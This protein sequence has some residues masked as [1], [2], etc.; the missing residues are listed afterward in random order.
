MHVIMGLSGFEV[1]NYQEHYGLTREKDKDGFYEAVG[2]QHSW[3]NAGS[4]FTFRLERHAAH[5]VHKFTPMQCCLSLERAP[6]LPYN[7]LYSM[8]I[9]MVPPLWFLIMDPA[10]E[11]LEDAKKGIQNEDKWNDEMPPSAADKKRYMIANTYIAF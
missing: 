3:S 1:M 7:W 5:H 8:M 9:S 4:A 11:S 10:V 6:T 2:F